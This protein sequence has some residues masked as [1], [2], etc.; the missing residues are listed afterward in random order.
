MLGFV[1][2]A[3]FPWT[4]QHQ[5]LWSSKMV[6]TGY[7]N[8]TSHT[9]FVFAYPQLALVISS[10]E[11]HLSGKVT[12]WETIKNSIR[13]SV[14]P[15]S[16]K[17]VGC[18]VAYAVPL[19]GKPLAAQWPSCHESFLSAVQMLLNDRNRQ[20]SITCHYFV[21]SK[22]FIYKGFTELTHSSVSLSMATDS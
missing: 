1:A 19:L 20:M 13:R 12:L 2:K 21:W 11:M 3:T 22:Y 16:N 9:I 5:L 4:T 7:W 14:F 17:S 18:F 8:C 10:T 15:L 6:Q